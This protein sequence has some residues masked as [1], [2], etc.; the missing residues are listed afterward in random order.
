MIPY[1]KEDKSKKYDKEKRPK[2]DNPDASLI[3]ILSPERLFGNY[4]KD[5]KWR[6]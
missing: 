3:D 1:K 4:I 2:E 6:R 5:M